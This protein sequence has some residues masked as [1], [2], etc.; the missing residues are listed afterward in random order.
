[1]VLSRSLFNVVRGY[2]VFP[3]RI[4]LASGAA[5]HNEEQT[6]RETGTDGRDLGGLTLEERLSLAWEDNRIS[7]DRGVPG[8]T[9][10]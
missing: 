6:E 4:L 2:G 1:M 9:I 5:R 3:G 7:S 10:K 8:D